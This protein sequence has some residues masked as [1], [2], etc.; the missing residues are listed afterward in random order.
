MS[1]PFLKEEPK[2]PIK[3][4]LVRLQGK[5]IPG[6]LGFSFYIGRKELFIG[7]EVSRVVIPSKVKR[8]KRKIDKAKVTFVPM[9]T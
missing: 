4:K 5:V 7:F 6:R 1:H 2:V 9:N 8:Y 3:E